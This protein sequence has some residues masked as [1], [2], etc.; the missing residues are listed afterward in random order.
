MR[1]P[2]SPRALYRVS[3]DTHL[4]LAVP[5]GHVRPQRGG[6]RQYERIDPN[7]YYRQHPNQNPEQQNASVPPRAFGGFAQ[8]PSL[9]GGGPWGDAAPDMMGTY[10][11]SAVVV[12][13]DPQGVLV[14]SH[15][16][17]D[18]LAHDALIVVR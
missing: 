18:L 10:S 3:A 12:P 2:S 11:P 6:R 13:Q 9:G 1:R 5:R 7:E 17:Y 15:A 8:G 4:P 14:D 16:A